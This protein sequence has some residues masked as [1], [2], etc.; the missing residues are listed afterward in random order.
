MLGGSSVCA[1]AKAM[2]TTCFYRT[3]TPVIP[4]PC[5]MT[6][7][8]GGWEGL[9]W[10]GATASN[11]GPS[12]YPPN[13]PP[14]LLCFFLLLPDPSGWHCGGWVSA[15]SSCLPAANPL[16]SWP[17]PSKPLRPW[18]PVPNLPPGSLLRMWG[19]QG[20]LPSHPGSR[21]WAESPSLEPLLIVVARV[22]GRESQ[23]Q[24]MD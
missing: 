10:L 6:L 24:V 23:Q 18:L 19:A 11:P 9:R 16:V 5:L 1:A 21:E 2:M 15:L 4:F 12:L 7:Q 3:M 14:P 13:P 17:L 22:H 8:A 20:L